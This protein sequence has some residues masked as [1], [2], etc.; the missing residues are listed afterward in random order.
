[1]ARC[2]G[3]L[4]VFLCVLLILSWCEALSSNVDD[5]YGHEDGSFESD[6]LLKLKDD[7]D[8]LSLKSSD[9]TTSESSTV[10]VLNFGAKGDGKTDDTQVYYTSLQFWIQN[11]FIKK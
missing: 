5:G 1:M 9:K 2:C 6:S 7:D 11:H 8:V 3:L 10:S 4:A